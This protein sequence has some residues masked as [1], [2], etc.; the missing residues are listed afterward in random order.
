MKTLKPTP[1]L[2]RWRILG[3][4]LP[5]PLKF[6]VSSPET[7]KISADFINEPVGE[8]KYLIEPACARVTD[9]TKWQ[10]FR[11]GA[12]RV[13]LT[14][15]DADAATR[16]KSEETDSMFES[17][18]E[19]ILVP[20]VNQSYSDKDF[21]P[22]E[23]IALFG[24]EVITADDITFENINKILSPL[25]VPDAVWRDN[26]WTTGCER[27]G[28]FRMKDKRTK[29]WF[30]GPRTVIRCAGEKHA[31]AM[32]KMLRILTESDEGNAKII[33]TELYRGTPNS[34]WVVMETI[35]DDALKGFARF[36]IHLAYKKDNEKILATVE[37]EVKQCLA[38]DETVDVARELGVYWNLVSRAGVKRAQYI[39]DENGIALKGV[40]GKPI[41][42]DKDKQ[43][44]DKIPKQGICRLAQGYQTSVI[45]SERYIPHNNK[46]NQKTNII[47]N[48][49][50]TSLGS[51]F[52]RTLVESINKSP[53][54]GPVGLLAKK[55]WQTP[56]EDS[57]FSKAVARINTGIVYGVL[58]KNRDIKTALMVGG[59]ALGGGLAVALVSVGASLACTFGYKWLKK[60]LIALHWMKPGNDPLSQWIRNIE[61]ETG[62][63]YNVSGI[64]QVFTERKHGPDSIIA[65]PY[66]DA[67]LNNPTIP[68]KIWAEHVRSQPELKFIHFMWQEKYFPSQE[69]LPEDDDIRFTALQKL[70]NLARL[71]AEYK[72]FSAG[73]AYRRHE[74][75]G[76]SETQNTSEDRAHDFK[77]SIKS[78]TRLEWQSGEIIK[79]KYRACL[80][81]LVQVLSKAPP[82]YEEKCYLEFIKELPLALRNGYNAYVTKCAETGQTTQAGAGSHLRG[83]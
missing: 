62:Y 17:H 20:A 48:Y 33:A 79:N 42:N 72:T 21:T 23:R 77:S 6:F 24:K 74:T 38:E 22:E 64:G 66:V 67:C 49:L 82:P 52:F 70:E 1:G 56:S 51:V 65:H 11:I 54:F 55:L 71:Y 58:F 8:N 9:L 43:I 4:I 12:I 40:L 39:E 37:G 34:E 18:I 73:I 31:R 69:L 44:L 60:G 7:K 27:N 83:A 76:N 32:A 78:I 47:D 15:L 16:F 45:Y 59:A 35:R 14:L 19:N 29:L 50:T 68:Q 75:V 30:N 28:E 80:K 10:R 2:Q 61:A 63:K 3:M 53:L 5:I 13:A 25:N 41:E 46:L 36:M 81:D 26:D 57:L